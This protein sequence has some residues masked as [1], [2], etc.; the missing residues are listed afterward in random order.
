MHVVDYGAGVSQPMHRHE[1]ATISLVRSGELIEETTGSA[2]AAYPGCVVVKPA[3]IAHA[4][5]FGPRGVSLLTIEIGCAPREYLWLANGEI[6]AEMIR[7]AN[8]RERGRDASLVE[9]ETLI[10]GG[11]A[12]ATRNAARTA[13]SLI[14]ARIPSRVTIE[15]IA[16]DVGVHPVAL[17]RSF[18]RTF[19]M[20][21]SAYAQQAR[22]RFAT[23]LLTSTRLSLADAA[24]D[25]GYADQSHLTRAV[26]RAY[27]VS[28]RRLRDGWI[29]SRFRVGEA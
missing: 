5:R 10:D 29:G 7:I 12:A 28:P 22:L 13:A 25:A 3:N 16:N 20:T 11:G 6:V 4:T 24:A 17:A 1:Q 18:R 23:R 8:A 14:E 21:T 27:G 19:G 2:W 9:L 15:E 26:R